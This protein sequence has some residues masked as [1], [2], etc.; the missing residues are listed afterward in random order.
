MSRESLAL[1][2]TEIPEWDEL[3]LDEA[4]LGPAAVKASEAQIKE[5]LTGVDFRLPTVLP[6]MSLAEAPSHETPLQIRLEGPSGYAYHLLAVPLTIILPAKLQLARLGMTLEFVDGEAERSVVAQA[7]SPTSQT[8]TQSH[9]YGRVSLDI[10]KALEFVFP[11]A[12]E[13]FGLQLAFPLRWESE[14]AVVQASG[15]NSNPASW[16]VEDEAVR[17]GFIGYVVTRSVP[18]A[19]FRVEA[20]IAAELRRKFL[21]KVRHARMASDRREYAVGDQ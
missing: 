6:R 18:T 19:P 10:S 21:G 9:E 14:H 3:D 8:V 7:L 5:I 2:S 20:T 15:F 11:P 17:N 16:R 1:H 13:C 12:A 4:Q